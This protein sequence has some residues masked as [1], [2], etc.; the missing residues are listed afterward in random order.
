LDDWV[1]AESTK[2]LAIQQVQT[3]MALLQQLGWMVNFK[4]SVST[5]TQQ[6]EHLSF[7]LNTHTMTASLPM[8]KLRDIRRSI[9]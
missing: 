8:K 3:V 7:V 9:K 4:K 5:P 2:Q 1:L 6:F